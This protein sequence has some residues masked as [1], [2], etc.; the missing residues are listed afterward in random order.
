[1]LYIFLKIEI[2]IASQSSYIYIKKRY[3]VSMKNIEHVGGKRTILIRV[4]NYFVQKSENIRTIS[5]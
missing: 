4:I 3:N 5:K 2:K 1:M